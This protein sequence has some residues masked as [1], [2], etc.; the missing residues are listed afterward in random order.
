M[1]A[2]LHDVRDFKELLQ[3][4]VETGCPYIW[5]GIFPGEGWWAGRRSKKKLRLLQRIDPAV[6]PMLEGG[7]QVFFVTTGLQHSFFEELFLG[8]VMY[9]LN[10]QAFVLTTKRILMIQI[11]SNDRPAHLR[12]Q[13]QYD[14]VEKVLLSWGK[15]KLRLRTGKTLLFLRIPKADREVFQKFLVAH[16][17][18]AVVPEGPAAGKENLCPHCYD[19]V[20]GLPDRCGGCGGSFKSARK[21]G[22]LSLLFPGLGD[23]YLGHRGIALLEMLGA[24]IVW[25]AILSAPQNDA[26]IIPFIIALLHVPDSFQTWRIGR[27][28]LYPGPSSLEC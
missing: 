3:E 13:I 15:C 18:R 1:A 26:A 9:Y 23:L 14:Q 5:K 12:A 11:R 21:A 24:G 22:A 7:E 16:H 2:T 4:G 10:R 17:A 27:K 8:Q 20:E 19:V 28:G 6:R 25:F